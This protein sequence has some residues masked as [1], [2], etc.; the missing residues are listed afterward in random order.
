MQMHQ[1]NP[2]TE[3]TAVLAKT[4]RWWDGVAITL[5]LPAALFVGLGYS[6]GAIGAWAAIALWAVIAAV[7]VLHNWLYSEMGAMFGEKSG[8][9][10]LYANEA[11][12]RRFPSLGPLATYAYWFAWA[13]APAIWGLAVAQILSEQFWP[14]VTFSYNLGPIQLGLPQF[15]ALGVALISWALSMI[16]LR[17]TMVILTV[18]G[19]LLMIPVLIFGTSF[20]TAD[21]WNTSSFTWRTGEGVEGLRTILAWL[22]IMAWSAYAVEAAASFI[23]EFRDTVADTRKALRIS[24]LIL[25]LVFTLTPLGLAGLLGEQVLTDKPYGFLQAGAEVL[26]GGGAAP[27]T[28]VLIAGIL[29]LS[30]MGTA[31]AG[32]ALYQSSRDGLTIRQFGTLNRAGVPARAVT[33]QLL[34]NILMVLLVGNPLAVIVA[35]NVGYI[36]AHLLAVSGYVMLRWDRPDAPRPICLS[37]SWTGI[38]IA[39]ALFDALILVVGMTGAAI[40]GYGGL[41]EVLIAVAVLTISQAL[42]WLRRLQDREDSESGAAHKAP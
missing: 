26:M 14:D 15:I 23:P 35:G 8:G 5:S 6:I 12:S 18:A 37:R 17:F 7:A 24:A 32:R 19:V 25:L 40:T 3:P 2:G 41:K 33:V 29:V 11:W 13:T 27:I 4:I 10:A 16:Q 38:A 28:L 36:L 9:I 21:V 1:A 39:L 30:V 22:F 42:Y 34:I 31:D 20:L